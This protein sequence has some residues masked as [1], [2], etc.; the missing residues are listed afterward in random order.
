MLVELQF[1]YLAEY[2]IKRGR[3]S[4]YGY[5]MGKEIF[6]VPEVERR[7]VE[8]DYVIRPR[9]SDLPVGKDPIETVLLTAEAGIYW[10]VCRKSDSAI[11]MVKAAKDRS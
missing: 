10:C 8:F 3:V 7:E 6:H 9:R 11:L 4:R 5:L 2:R 1:P